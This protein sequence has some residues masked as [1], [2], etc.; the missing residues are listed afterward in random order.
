MTGNPARKGVFWRL[1]CAGHGV[2]EVQDICVLALAREF[3]TCDS[4]WTTR[5]HVRSLCV[6]VRVC[7]CMC[8]PV[9]VFV[10]VCV[11]VC[12]FVYVCVCVPML[13]YV[14]VCVCV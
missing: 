13:V 5:R 8:V 10:Y 14:R 12:V 7:V 6:C 4:D 1:F 9:C 3:A 2:E 11:C